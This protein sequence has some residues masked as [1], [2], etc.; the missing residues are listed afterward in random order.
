MVERDHQSRS[1]LDTLQFKGR[2]LVKRLDKRV[3]CLPVVSPMRMG[4]GCS[5]KSKQLAQQR[6]NWLPQERWRARRD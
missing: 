3:I 4:C 5:F 1:I 6:F 2:G